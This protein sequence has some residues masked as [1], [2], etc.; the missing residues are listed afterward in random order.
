LEE[1]KFNLEMTY[2]NCEFFEN[3][4]ATFMYTQ[5]LDQ[6]I[7]NPFTCSLLDGPRRTEIRN[8]EEID[9]KLGWICLEDPV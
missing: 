2:L 5:I 9:G 1:L 3:F 4:P 7:N 8:I 6:T